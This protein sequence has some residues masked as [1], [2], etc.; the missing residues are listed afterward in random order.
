V[1][2]DVYN[3]GTFKL[4]SRRPLATY[5]I[6]V[7]GGPKS[8]ADIKTI[9]VIRANGKVIS[10]KMVRVKTIG[11]EPGDVVIVPAKLRYP[12]TFKSFMDVADA[13]LKVGSFMT[14]L[15]T[16]IVTVNLMNN[17]K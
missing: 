4:D 14:A 9:Y 6:D 17:A 3:P 11:L 5:Y 8:S 15:I 10:N 1:L 12:N 13:T 2:G 7:A 16:L